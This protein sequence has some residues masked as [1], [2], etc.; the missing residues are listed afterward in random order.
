MYKKAISALHVL[1]IV[2]QSI[3]TLLWQIA[4]GFGIGYLAVN[5]WSAPS[6]IYVPLILAGVFSGLVSMVRFLL[7]AM[8]SLERLEAQHE[9]DA[10]ER[11]KKRA[12]LDATHKE[13]KSENDI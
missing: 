13:N 5:Y 7:A 4:L 8:N 6:W 10:K 3:F 9:K 2:S 12:S 11:A 1:N